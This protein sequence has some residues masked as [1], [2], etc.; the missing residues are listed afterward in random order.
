LQGAT[1]KGPKVQ[2][3]ILVVEDNIDDARLLAT[4]LTTMGHKVEYAINGTVAV[5]LANR[6]APE[7]VF[8]D[9]RLPDAHGAEVARRILAGSK[10]DTRVYAVTGSSDWKDFE[11]AKKAGCV[12]VLVKPVAPDQ[13]ERILNN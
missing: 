7:F 12:D 6:F 8:I 13:F 2:W 9:L 1:A 4:L 10:A 3:K 5:D 11:R